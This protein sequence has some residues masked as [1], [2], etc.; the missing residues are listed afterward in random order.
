MKCVII[1][2]LILDKLPISFTGYSIISCTLVT[3]QDDNITTITMRL[4]RSTD[5]DSRIIVGT[6]VSTIQITDD[7]SMF[8]L[9]YI[10]LSHVILCYYRCYGTFEETPYLCAGEQGYG[11]SMCHSVRPEIS[12]I[13]LRSLFHLY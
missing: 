11:A 6:D 8:I 7:P 13:P 4:E 9:L 5:L 10:R 3:T 1:S 12:G 2:F